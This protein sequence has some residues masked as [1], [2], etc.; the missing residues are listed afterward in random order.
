MLPEAVCDW[1]RIGKPDSLMRRAKARIAR[2]RVHLDAFEFHCL[3]LGHGRAP[4]PF[5]DFR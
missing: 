5:D 1:S 4:F 3:C 2:H